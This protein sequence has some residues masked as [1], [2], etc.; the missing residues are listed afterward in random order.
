[1]K[2]FLALMRDRRG[3]GAA[4][5]ALVLPLL[6]LLLLGVIDG[7]RFLWEVNRAEKATQFGARYAIVTD[8]IP[9]AIVNDDYVGRTY[10][11]NDIDATADTCTAG[12]NF[13]DTN[14]LG[15]LTC[16]SSACTCN[17]GYC[18]GGA[19]ISAAAFTNLVNRMQLMDPRIAQSNV[20]VVFKGSGLGFAGDPNGM[21]V[22]PLV[23]VQLTG[24]TF[25]PISL[26]NAV[27]FTLPNFATTLT[28]ES[29][30]GTLSN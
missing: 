30:T 18:P 10:C 25:T 23:T 28:A 13:F 29:S 3:G 6:L 19:S 1:M 4:E 12:D 11:E 20:Q 9:S 16:T 27:D 21:D 26:F 24:M 8:V 7:G 14:T 2:R 5:F 22:I 17:S 15:K